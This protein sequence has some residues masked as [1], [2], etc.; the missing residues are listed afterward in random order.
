MTDKLFKYNGLL[1]P[2]YLKN[3]NA[4]SYIFPFAQQFCKG[5]GIDIGGTDSCHFPG[6]QII[7]LTKHD[8]YDAYFLPPGP[9]DFIFSSHTLEHITNWRYVLHSWHD[10]LV[11]GTG[12][13]FLYLPHPDMLYWHPDNCTKHLHS[14]TP[15]MVAN[16]LIQSGFSDVIYSQRDLYWS[17]SVVAFK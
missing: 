16:H 11:P 1:Y 9:F 15:L 2:F 4:A 14:F 17:F 6:A 12:V 8:G 3:G 13:L 7:N 5:R 10:R